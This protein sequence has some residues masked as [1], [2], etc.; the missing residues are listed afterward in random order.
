MFRVL[1]ADT[2]DELWLKA[3]SWFEPGGLAAQQ[4]SRC[5]DTTEVLH[6]A[7]SLSDP[8]QR[9]TASRSPAMNPAFALAEVIWIVSGRND[10]AFLNFFNPKLPNY[11]GKGPTYHGAYGFR[12]R[13]HF[14]FDQLERA[15]RALSVDG[16]S[17]QVVLQIWDGAADLPGEDGKPQYPDIP[18]NLTSLLK[19]REN[20]LEW[21]Q[22]MRS[23]DLVLG[24]PHNIVQFTSLQEIMAGWLNVEV[25]GYHH[26]ADSLHLYDK[27][28]PVK[29]RMDPQILSRNDDSIALPKEESDEAFSRLARLCDELSSPDTDVGGALE[30]FSAADLNSSFRNWACVLTADA[31]RRKIA[32]REVESV[33]DECTNPCLTEMFERWLRRKSGS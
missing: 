31:L 10:S 22:I 4:D 32:Y 17:R 5:G 27:H 29:K 3:A 6:A 9:W 13:K 2:A 18:C 19:L 8:R 16:I 14:G 26:F 33:M 21:T 30:A 12:L 1:E 7:L 28:A 24:V 20:R 23:N 15:Y 25:G 11:A